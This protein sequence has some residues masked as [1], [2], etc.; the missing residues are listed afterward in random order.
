MLA[1]NPRAKIEIIYLDPLEGGQV[2]AFY[3]EAVRVFGRINAVVNVGR[4]SPTDQ[5]GSAAVQA[6]QRVL[7]TVRF[8]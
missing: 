6:Y 7:K 2:N 5:E 1:Q 4:S 8:R 3:A